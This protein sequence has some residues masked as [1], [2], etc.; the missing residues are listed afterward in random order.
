MYVNVF[1]LQG[2]YVC[3]SYG[4]LVVVI[5]FPVRVG[6]SWCIAVMYVGWEGSGACVFI[7]GISRL[8][9]LIT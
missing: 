2:D 1:R 6:C 5:S 9:S 3:C 4:V 7:I 8:I